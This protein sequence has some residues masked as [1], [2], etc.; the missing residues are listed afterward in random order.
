MKKRMTKKQRKY[1]FKLL[2]IILNKYHCVYD[3]V[4][5]WGNP[6]YLTDFTLFY[7]YKKDEE[8]FDNG[9]VVKIKTKPSYYVNYLSK[10][11]YFYS[12]IK[13]LKFTKKEASYLIYKLKNKI[14]YLK[15]K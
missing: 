10:N 5:F 9:L 13:D 11:D 15:E 1:L 4:D 12:K 14:K 3:K 7:K 2:G 6:K 8:Y